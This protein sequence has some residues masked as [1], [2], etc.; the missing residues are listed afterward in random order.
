[1]ACVVLLFEEEF[2]VCDFACGTQ[3]AHALFSGVGDS[4]GVVAPIFK[5]FEVVYCCF[6]GGAIA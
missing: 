2:E 5:A 4:C 3:D 6:D 1:M